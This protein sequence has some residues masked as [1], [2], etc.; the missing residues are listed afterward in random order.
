MIPNSNHTRRPISRTLPTLSRVADSLYWMSRYL[1]RAEHTAR[2]VYVNFD[3]MLD[4]TPQSGTQR[5]VRMLNSLRV[6]QMPRSHEMYALLRWLTVDQTNEA[7]IVYS[8]AAARENARQVREQLSSEMWQQLNQ[9]YLHVRRTSKSRTWRTQPHRFF[10]SV[11][12]GAHLFQGITD[13]TMTHSEGWRFIQ[14]GRCIERVWG[15]TALLGAHFAAVDELDYLTWVGLLRSCTAFEAYC[16]VYTADVRPDCV[17]EFLLLDSQFPHSVRFCVDLLQVELQTIASASGV[18][19]HG[20]VERLAG[21]LRATL[22]YAQVEEVV[23]DMPAY[24]GGIQRQCAEIHNA[25]YQ[26]YID[27]AVDSAIT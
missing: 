24:L 22:D 26:V 10:H 11:K 3:Q 15:I 20:R 9:L 17:A 27:Y 18:Q 4:E 5:M 7:S 16:K 2:V 1:E 21:R 14:V 6:N 13:S 8:I 25:I 19:N 12:D 23:H